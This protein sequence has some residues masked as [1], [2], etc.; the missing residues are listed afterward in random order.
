VERKT[1]NL[2]EYKLKKK[3]LGGGQQFLHTESQASQGYSE[4]LS[5]KIPKD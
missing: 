2:G 1:N 4:T 3:K 5:P